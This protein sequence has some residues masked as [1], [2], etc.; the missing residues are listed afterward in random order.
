VIPMLGPIF[1]RADMF[2]PFGASSL[3]DLRATMGAALADPSV[4]GIL[5]VI[6]SP[7]GEVAGV[8]DLADELHAMRGR[9]PMMAVADEG[10]FSAAYWIGSA[11]GPVVLPRTGGVGSVGALVVHT[12]ISGALD[13]MGVR[14]SVVKSGPKKAQFSPF[15]PLTADARQAV[16]A[17]VDR[18]SELC[19][20]AVAQHRGLDP[21]TVR[22]L[23]GGTLQGDAAVDGGLADGI[24]TVEG[25]YLALQMTLREESASRRL[26]ARRE[27]ERTMA[28]DNPLAGK[29]PAPA[30]K[31][32]P[33]AATAPASLSAEQT[34]IVSL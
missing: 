25:A 8:A 21:E 26:G 6:D 15:A 24:D 9:K 18:V 3:N 32:D 20:S 7:G 2:T 31:E 34:N 10:M 23:E 30:P 5:L 29:A 13:R 17:E 14:V 22:G 28:I 33:V 19:I 11:V 16:Q 1:Q 12:D 27:G 4:E